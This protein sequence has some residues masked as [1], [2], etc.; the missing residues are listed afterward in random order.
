MAKQNLGD[1]V[2]KLS[3]FLNNLPEKAKALLEKIIDFLITVFSAVPVWVWYILGVLLVVLGVL[4]V[5]Y[6][7]KHNDEWKRVYY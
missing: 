3:D 6:I 7:R 4:I 2:S 5:L 1:I